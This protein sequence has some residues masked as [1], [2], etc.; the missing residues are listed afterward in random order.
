VAEI[1]TQV[2]PFNHG[3]ALQVFRGVVDAALE[4]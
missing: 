2:L 3:G 4:K 1:L